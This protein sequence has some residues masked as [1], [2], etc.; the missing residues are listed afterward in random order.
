[1]KFLDIFKSKEKEP[2]KIFTQ[3]GEIEPICP[4]CKAILKKMPGRKIKCLSCNK[5][6]VVKTRALDGK[7][8][9]IKE[10]EIDEVERQWAIKKGTLDQYNLNLEIK[11]K[12][13]LRFENEKRKLKE[14]FGCEPRDADVQWALFNIDRRNH[15][16]NGQWGLYI[17]TTMSMADQLKKEQKFNQALKFYLEVC[18]FDI[19]EPS[20]S[21]NISTDENFLKGY[22]KM[23]GK[24]YIL[25]PRISPAI[26]KTIISIQKKENIDINELKE[27]FLKHNDSSYNSNPY[28]SI[29]PKE[30]W[31]I[32]LEAYNQ[33]I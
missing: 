19:N 5:D 30:A 3:I 7:K 18:Y 6:I 11:N 13:K 17:N 24:D 21:G 22:K 14:R 32:F 27:I 20:N 31:E 10:E 26:L 23:Y 33:S 29:S 1:M 2:D 28:I 25:H 4:Y 12:E 8:I 9:L 16:V 15:F